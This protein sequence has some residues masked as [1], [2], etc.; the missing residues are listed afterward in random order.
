MLNVKDFTIHLDVSIVV[1]YFQSKGIDLCEMAS[2]CVMYK[3]REKVATV[4]I[5]TTNARGTDVLLSIIAALGLLEKVEHAPSRSSSAV[6][7][8]WISYATHVVSRVQ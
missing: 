5:V 3:W 1:V 7:C 2:V 4:A 6:L 8:L